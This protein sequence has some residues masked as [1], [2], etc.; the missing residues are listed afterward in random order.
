MS[1]SHLAAASSSNFELIINNAL[2]AYERRTKEDLHTHPLALQ[3][4]ACKSPAAILTVL[5]AEVSAHW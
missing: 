2:K 3:L 5:P 4:K 1:Q